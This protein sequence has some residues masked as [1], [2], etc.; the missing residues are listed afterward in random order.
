MNQSMRS[1]RKY[2]VRKRPKY[3]EFVT[4]CH[5]VRARKMILSLISKIGA[6]PFFSHVLG[7]FFPLGIIND[8][9]LGDLAYGKIF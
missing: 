9:V 6:E 5:R 4:L 8:L 2:N 3:F 1:M 7:H